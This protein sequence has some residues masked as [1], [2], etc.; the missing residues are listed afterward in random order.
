[1]KT[2]YLSLEFSLLNVIV[3]SKSSICSF[4]RGITHL[5]RAGSYN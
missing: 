5:D 1:M 4:L 2:R 3:L